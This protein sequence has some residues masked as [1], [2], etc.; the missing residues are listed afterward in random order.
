MRGFGKKYIIKMKKYSE[1]WLHSIA[2][3]RKRY[4]CTLLGSSGTGKTYLANQCREKIKKMGLD[5]PLN[6]NLG[7]RQYKPAIEIYAIIYDECQAGG[8]RVY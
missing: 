8:I 3:G 7:I 5:Y 1:E 4:W 6:K 2:L